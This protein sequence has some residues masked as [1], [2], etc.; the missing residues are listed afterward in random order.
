MSA[1]DLWQRL[2]GFLREV[3]PLFL[4]TAL[5][6]VILVVPSQHSIWS[7]IKTSRQLQ[8]KRQEY[9]YYKDEIKKSQKHLD[10]IKYKKDMLEKYARETY[11]MKEDNEDLYLLTDPDKK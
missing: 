2:K 1:Q 8:E 3:N 6:V 10:E 9:Q 5:F 11:L 4:M 7:Q